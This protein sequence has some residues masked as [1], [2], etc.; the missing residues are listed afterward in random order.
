MGLHK[1]KDGDAAGESQDDDILNLERINDFVEIAFKAYG[2]TQRDAYKDELVFQA[3]KEVITEF[4]KYTMLKRCANCSAWVV[5][6]A[7]T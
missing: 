1:T 3:R 4:L 7:C 6:C 5:L 2:K